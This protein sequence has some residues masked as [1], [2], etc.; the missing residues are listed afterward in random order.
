MDRR[1]R[2]SQGGLYVKYCEKLYE[3]CPLA[4]HNNE[5]DGRLAYL[6]FENGDGNIPYIVRALVANKGERY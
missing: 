4:V 6:G 5:N 2:K 1:R 3:Q